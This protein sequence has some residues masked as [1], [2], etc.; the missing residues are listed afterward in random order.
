MGLYKAIGVFVLR[1][2]FGRRYINMLGL[3]QLIGLKASIPN[4]H[5]PTDVSGGF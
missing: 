2:S 4:F 3:I 5:P 1:L